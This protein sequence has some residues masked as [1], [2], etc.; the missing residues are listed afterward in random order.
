MFKKDQVSI[1][2]KAE[3]YVVAA[4][5]EGNEEKATVFNAE[6][7]IA[8]FK[9]GVSNHNACILGIE[10][11]ENKFGP[12][13]VLINNA[14]ITRYAVFHKMSREQCSNVIRTN[15]DGVFNMTHRL[16][17]RIRQ[18]KFGLVI[19]ISSKKW[20]KRSICKSK[21]I[22]CK[23]GDIGFTKAL[24]QEGARAGITVNAICPDCISTEMVM[25]V[26][27]K[28]C[29]T[30]FPQIPVGRLRGATEIA[31]CIIFVA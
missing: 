27:E 7:G 16:R 24:A 20:T 1:A 2:L 26:P 15:L 25:A 13:E 22:C 17:N 6:T 11:I 14:G 29:E 5:F 3:G 18:R 31:C 10:K 8:T 28:V 30:I 21:L 9:W 12:V 23:A 19:N 4:T